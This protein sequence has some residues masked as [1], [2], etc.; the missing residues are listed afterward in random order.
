MRRR[1]RRRRRGR[2]RFLAGENIIFEYSTKR[3]K[4][5]NFLRNLASDG[6]KE[7]HFK[8]IRFL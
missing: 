2:R 4:N 6:A 3:M 7:R 8:T 5:K 1:I